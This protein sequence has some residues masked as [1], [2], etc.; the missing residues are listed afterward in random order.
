MSVHSKPYLTAEDYLAFERSAETRS[1]YVDGEMVAMAGASREHNLIV[2]NL[3]GELRSQLKGRPCELYPSDLRVRVPATGLYTYSDVVVVCGEPRFEDEHFDTLLNPSLVIE[4]LSA[5][6]EGYDRGKKFEH[7]RALDSLR[8][9]LLVSQDEPLVEQ[10]VRQEDGAWRFTATSG[11]DAVVHL[12]SLGC[13][14][15]LA[16]IYDK[17]PLP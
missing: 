5:S 2:T 16:E 13:S 14:L 8:E 17:V 7:Y 1:E 9:Y 11:R 12:P 4:V 6:T 15:A 3:L 10:F